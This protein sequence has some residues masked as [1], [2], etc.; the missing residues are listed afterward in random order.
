[1]VLF[2]LVSSL[3]TVR[4]LAN[5]YTDVTVTEAKTM[6]DQDPSLVILDVRNQSEYDAGHIR[7]AGL[8]PVWQLA[9]RL[10]ELNKTDEILVYCKLGARSADASQILESNSFL[11][12]YNMLGG[13]IAW[14]AIG[15]P[16]YVRYPSLQEAINNATDGD[17]INVSSGIYY[18]HL[19][20][21]KSLTLI[22]EN[23]YTTIIDG[24]SNGT[25]VSIKADN[26]AIVGLT[27]QESGCSCAGY[28]GVFVGAPNQD[29]NLTNNRIIQDGF[30][31]LLLG[32]QE[33]DIDQN[34]IANCTTAIEILYSSNNTITENNIANNSGGIELVPSSNNIIEGNNI[35]NSAGACIKLRSSDQNIFSR[36]RLT[37]SQCGIRLYASSN[38]TLNDNTVAENSIGIETLNITNHKIYQNNFMKNTQQVYFQ[39]PEYLLNLT[40]TWNNGNTWDDGNLPGGNYWSNYAGVDADHDG[41]GDSPHILDPNNID[42][43]PLM[44]TFSSFTTSTGK[45][46]EIVSNSTIEDLE[47]IDSNKT[48]K[49]HVSNTT[50]DQT[51]G[52][53]R[54]T[55]PHDLLSPPYDVIVNNEF[56][57]YNTTYEDTTLTIIY[58]SYQ[59]STLEIV[60]VPEFQP[61]IL[62]ILFIIMTLSVLVAYRRRHPQ[63]RPLT[64]SSNTRKTTRILCV[65]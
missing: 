6:I 42:N 27:I 63:N 13:I 1:L 25:V 3:L 23:K 50:E 40:D 26:V 20:I 48:I 11:H 15:Y 21:N 64:R 51:S 34:E 29:A 33:I 56:I 52:F 14:T 47:Y 4:T 28:A 18:E 43:Y 49:I 31:V 38:N 2:I 58:F 44:A 17:T 62:L 32:A 36:N 9:S 5:G 59:H 53:C 45:N 24:T 60:V 61:L 39:E 30:G 7:N 41:I 8:I 35:T 37:D 16:V 10:N 57:D 54:L 19:A 22:G 12:V 65:S 55:I 46:V